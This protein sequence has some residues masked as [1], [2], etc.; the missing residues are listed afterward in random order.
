MIAP[1]FEVARS[2]QVSPKFYLDKSI[3][4][5]ATKTE[6]TKLKNKA[7]SEL[8]NLFDTNQNKLFYIA[9]ALDGNSAQYK[10]YTPNDIIYENMDKYINGKG[11]ETNL[12]RAAKSFLD[13]SALDMETLK[14]RAIIKDSTFYKFIILKADGFIYHTKTASLIGR[15]VADCIEY[16]K[17]PL[18]E[19]ILQDLLKNVEKMW[20]Q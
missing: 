12:K 17:N 13:A 6:V 3:D 7:I 1:S 11:I 16:L 14:L 15:N 9:K 20:N 8:Q 5:I 10:K 2:M 4:T 18:N 19:E